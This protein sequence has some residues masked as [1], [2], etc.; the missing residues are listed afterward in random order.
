MLH[1]QYFIPTPE[2]IHSYRAA[3]DSQIGSGVG[4]D[5]LDQSVR[6][7]SWTW[8]T[9]PITEDSS[10]QG[11]FYLRAQNTF[12]TLWGCGTKKK[13]LNNNNHFITHSDPL[14]S[15]KPS[16]KSPV[17][18]LRYLR[19]S[20]LWGNI[21]FC[22]LQPQQKCNYLFS[23]P[24]VQWKISLSCFSTCRILKGFS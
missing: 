9:F 12:F 19:R 14:H 16:I 21:T 22:A 10:E 15:L 3:P 1:H 11:D 20:L 17:L 8:N 18:K 2:L 23:P 6:K 4:S 13:S 24:P 7:F 5:Q